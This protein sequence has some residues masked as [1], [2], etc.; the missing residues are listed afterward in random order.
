MAHITSLISHGLA[1]R[2]DPY[3]REVR[4]DINIFFGLNGSG[5]TSLLKIL[6]SA[7]S[8][9]TAILNDVP[10]TTA[11]VSIYSNNYK[12]NFTYSVEQMKII[13]A[14]ETTDEIDQ[15]I[16]YTL[17]ESKRQAQ[18]QSSSFTWN[19]KPKLPRDAKGNWAHQYLPTSRL[20]A[21]ISS[22]GNV[23]RPQV[24]SEE[25]LDLIFSDHLQ[26]L[27]SQYSSN[28]LRIVRKAQEDG[29][30]NIFKAI[31]SG[32][33]RSEEGQQV[34]PEIAYSRVAAFLNRQGSP[35]S[36]GSFAAFKKRYARDLSFR[37]V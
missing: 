11:E 20:Y 6:H 36:L 24:R 34:D 2:R 27:W 28:I 1:G 18:L 37:N 3:K 31:L 22:R 32:E 16:L 23:F 21:G 5:K 15:A 9:D 35:S 25:Q 17:E 12:K 29:L 13:E 30:A 14:R 26:R 10:F 7:M 8:N 33:Q 19:I 4:E